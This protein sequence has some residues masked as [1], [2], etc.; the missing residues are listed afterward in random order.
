MVVE[1]E[2]VIIQII[3]AML[4]LPG[5]VMVAFVLRITLFFLRVYSRT[6]A[7]KK[8]NPRDCL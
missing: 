2:V 4:L 8:T 5:M 1:I 6:K 7:S 3:G